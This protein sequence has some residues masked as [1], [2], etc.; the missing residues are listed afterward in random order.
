MRT[1]CAHCTVHPHSHHGSKLDVPEL[2]FNQFSSGTT[3]ETAQHVRRDVALAP[4]FPTKNEEL[5]WGRSLATGWYL[6][7]SEGFRYSPP[8][9]QCQLKSVT[10][11]LLA[12]R[13]QSGTTV[14]KLAYDCLRISV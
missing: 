11:V 7:F 14:L 2:G 6:F 9:I 1:A 12:N 10:V 3:A 13:Y 5:Y 8:A 4:G